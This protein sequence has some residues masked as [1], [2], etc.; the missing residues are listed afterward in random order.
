MAPEQIEGKEA[1]ARS[2]IFALGAVLHEMATGKKAF[3]GTSPPGV[4]AGV[5]GMEPPA[6]ASFQPDTPPA[7][8]RLVRACLAKDPAER[9]QS[10]HDLEVE[11]KW[12]RGREPRSGRPVID[13]GEQRRSLE[14]LAWWTAIGALV[15]AVGMIVAYWLR[16]EPGGQAPI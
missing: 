1:D 11:L 2:D 14:R 12:I 15:L 3:P 13:Q 6:I 9:L 10:A 4:A 7:L 16:P 5:V 8:D